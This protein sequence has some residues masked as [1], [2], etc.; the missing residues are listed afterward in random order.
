VLREVAE[1]LGADDDLS[2]EQLVLD[3]WHDLF[4]NRTLGWGYNIDNSNFPWFHVRGFDQA[5]SS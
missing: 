3:C 2:L 5:A 1:R 4:L